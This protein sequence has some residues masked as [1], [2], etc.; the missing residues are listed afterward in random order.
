MKR[1][2]GLRLPPNAARLLEDLPG[3]EKLLQE[4]ATKC[5][6]YN[7]FFADLP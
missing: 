1:D 4:K 6:G 7:F 3:T 2:G 5:A